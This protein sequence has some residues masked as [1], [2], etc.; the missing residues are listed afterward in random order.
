M[1]YPRSARYTIRYRCEGSRGQIALIVED[2][3]GM[4][5]LF[6]DGQLQGR[7]RG[8]DACAFLARKLAGS[9]AWTPVPRVTPYTL[10]GLRQLTEVAPLVAQECGPPERVRVADRTGTARNGMIGP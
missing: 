2:G 1:T 4:A 10:S 3:A 9:G 5:Y 8:D 7:F 6:G